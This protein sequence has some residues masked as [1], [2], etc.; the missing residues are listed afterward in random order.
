M[1][2]R[3]RF[4]DGLG[5]LVERGASGGG[6]HRRAVRLDARI[7]KLVRQPRLLELGGVRPSLR[8][9]GA[10]AGGFLDLGASRVGVDGGARCSLRGGLR[11]GGGGLGGIRASRRGG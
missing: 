11:L 5:R 3:L 10:V 2:A 8:G 9:G 1:R 6:V 4:A 7:E